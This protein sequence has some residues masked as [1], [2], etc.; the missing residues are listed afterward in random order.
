MRDL[1]GARYFVG[2]G[3]LTWDR[4]ERIGDRYGAIKLY[5]DPDSDRPVALHEPPVTRGHLEAVVTRTRDSRHIG[6]LFHGVFP[7]RPD[8]GEVIKLG[9]PGT[10]FFDDDGAIG[11]EPDDDR[12]TLWMDIRA[13]YRAHEQDVELFVVEER[14]T[15]CSICSLPIDRPGDEIPLCGPCEATARVAGKQAYDAMQW[16]KDG[17]P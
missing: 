13:L 12:D 3:C 2:A 16:E 15:S 10:V 4:H 9:E 7:V 11:V 14:L 6:D 17:R 5:P 8:V 1:G